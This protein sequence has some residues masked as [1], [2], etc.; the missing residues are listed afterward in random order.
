MRSNV[1]AVC[2]SAS[3]LCVWQSL[4]QLLALT[5]PV[6]MPETKRQIVGRAGHF[7]PDGCQLAL[8]LTLLLLHLSFMQNPESTLWSPV[9]IRSECDALGDC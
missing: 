4:Q 6:F 9:M 2:S 1:S 8:S 3:Q 5:A 7:L